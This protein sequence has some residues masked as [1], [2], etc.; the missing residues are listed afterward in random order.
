[1]DFLAKVWK[2]QYLLHRKVALEEAL[3]DLFPLQCVLYCYAAQAH[4]G[5]TLQ[6]C[7]AATRSA[8]AW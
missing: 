6:I 8:S 7:C 3:V 5:H 1:M 4:N 2:T